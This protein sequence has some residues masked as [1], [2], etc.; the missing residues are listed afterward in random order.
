MNKIR[1]NVF[2]RIMEIAYVFENFKNL[3]IVYFELTVI[4][5]V[6]FNFKKMSDKQMIKNIRS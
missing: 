5:K 3:E 4:I 1:N 2:F 6:T